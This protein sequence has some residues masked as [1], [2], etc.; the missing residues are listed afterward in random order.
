MLKPIALAIAFLSISINIMAQGYDVTFSEEIKLK[1]KDKAYTQEIIGEDEDYLFLLLTDK[2]DGSYS[3]NQIF[4][5]KIDKN[6][7]KIKQ[8]KGI[9]SSKSEKRQFPYRSLFK[10]KD[11]FVI[12]L[13]TSKK[14]VNEVY[15]MRLDNDLNLALERKKIY[16]YNSKE[17]DTRLLSNTKAN[18]FVLLSQKYVEEGQR[19][20]VVYTAF[21]EEFF[22]TY[23]IGRKPWF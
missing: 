20:D 21:D 8:Q 17:E 4:I 1:G 19:I 11:G 6:T 2:S 3:S 14:N 23:Q 5:Q 15:A 22:Q 9:Y 12:F 10:T 18:D 13:E 7:L 16:T